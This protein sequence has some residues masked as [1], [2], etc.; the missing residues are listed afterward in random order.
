MLAIMFLDGKDEGKQSLILVNFLLGLYVEK[1]YSSRLSGPYK[2][3]LPFVFGQPEL[4]EFIHFPF[5]STQ[6]KTHKEHSCL[7]MQSQ[8]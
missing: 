5:T 7:S 8:F 4:L 6:D 1:K 2:K 3:S